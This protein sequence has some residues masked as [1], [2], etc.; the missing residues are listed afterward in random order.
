MIG[1]AAEVLTAHAVIF[2]ASQ[3]GVFAL[4]QS[5][6]RHCISSELLETV[7]DDLSG[8]KQNVF[9]KLVLT[10][11][12]RDMTIYQQAVINSTPDDMFM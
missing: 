12:T 10:T 5:Q 11:L 6:Q 2:L 3:Q 8:N 1:S 4:I 9:R 7:P